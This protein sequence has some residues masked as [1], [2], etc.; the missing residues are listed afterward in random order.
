[1]EALEQQ[2]EKERKESINYV[3][4]FEAENKDLKDK[5]RDL[6]DRSRRDNFVLMV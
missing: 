1:M 2:F 6:E 5:L 3:K 4:S